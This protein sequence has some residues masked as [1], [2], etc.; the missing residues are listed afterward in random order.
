M[1]REERETCSIA[2]AITS[3]RMHDLLQR[4]ISEKDH[5]PDEHQHGRK[6]HSFGRG[7]CVSLDASHLMGTQRRR[8]CRQ[9]QLDARA[10]LAGE[11]DTGRDLAELHDTDAL[12]EL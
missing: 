7:L 8:L 3:K 6:S 5:E 11:F 9:R 2:E 10:L 4:R 12:A 1:V